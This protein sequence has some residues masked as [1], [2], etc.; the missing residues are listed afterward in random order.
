[1]LTE[2]RFNYQNEDNAEINAPKEVWNPSL[3]A[4]TGTLYAWL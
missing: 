4:Q 2:M 1:M 3:V